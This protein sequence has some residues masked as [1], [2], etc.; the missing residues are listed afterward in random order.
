ML[1]G[2]VDMIYMNFSMGGWYILGFYDIQ[3]QFDGKI[4]L[5][6]GVVWFQ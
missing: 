6:G 5:I 2:S 4:L 1:D 3:L